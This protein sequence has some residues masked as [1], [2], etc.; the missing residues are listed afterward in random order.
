MLRFAN[1][2]KGDWN[3][4]P[5]IAGNQSLAFHIANLNEDFQHTSFPTCIM[6]HTKMNWLHTC[7]VKIEND[8]WIRLSGQDSYLYILRQIFLFLEKVVWKHSVRKN[9]LM[10]LFFHL[11]YIG[12]CYT[13]IF[14]ILKLSKTKYVYTFAKF[15]VKIF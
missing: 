5:I 13:V 2:E 1:I 14:F 9:E 7:Q 8:C 6:C 10:Y 4:P 3:V 12:K 11:S 15:N